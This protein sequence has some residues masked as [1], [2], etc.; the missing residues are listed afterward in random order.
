M[1]TENNYY[2][3][4]NDKNNNFKNSETGKKVNWNKFKLY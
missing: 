1:I 4:L 3:S 2:K